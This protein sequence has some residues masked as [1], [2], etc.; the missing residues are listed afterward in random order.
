MK[1]EIFENT[2]RTEVNYSQLSSLMSKYANKE[3]V[4]SEIAG[5]DSIVAILEYLK[6]KKNTYVIPTIV[7]TGTEYGRIESYFDSIEFLNKKLKSQNII[8]TPTVILYDYTLWNGMNSKISGIL[9][10]KYGNFSSCVGCH[11]YTHLLRIPIASMTKTTDIITGERKLHGNKIKINQTAPVLSF[12]KEIINNAGYELL[13]PISDIIDESMIREAFDDDMVFNGANDFKCILS[14][15]Y[16]NYQ[17]GV[18]VTEDT[19]KN[20]IDNYYRPL[21]KH[22]IGYLKNPQDL[23][24][25]DSINKEILQ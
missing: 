20:I 7:L 22:L 4:I 9:S 16:T 23:L 21:S 3:T 8:F 1:F 12:F 13:S 19:V 18:S 17:G 2:T 24:D 14:G 6:N 5:R 10:E 11:F 25:I 15:N